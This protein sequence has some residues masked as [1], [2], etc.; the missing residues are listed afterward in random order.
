M[1][2]ILVAFVNIPICFKNFRLR[3]MNRA[4]PFKVIRSS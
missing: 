4:N 1:L 2:H 3:N